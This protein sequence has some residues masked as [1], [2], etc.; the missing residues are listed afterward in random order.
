MIAKKAVKECESLCDVSK[1]IKESVDL[2]FHSRWDSDISYNHMCCHY[3]YRDL[4]FSV[5]IK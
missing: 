4:S 1:Q 3:T 5:T 2:E